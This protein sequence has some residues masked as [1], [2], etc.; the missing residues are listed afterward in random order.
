MGVEDLEL[1]EAPMMYKCIH[2]CTFHS[3]TQ[4]CFMGVNGARGE[5]REQVE[6]ARGRRENMWSA[7]AGGERTGGVHPGSHCTQCSTYINTQ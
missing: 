1:I 4:A 5:E 7:P 6:C 2:K 3:S